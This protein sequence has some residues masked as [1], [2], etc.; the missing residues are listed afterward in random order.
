[1]NN[2]KFYIEMFLIVVLLIWCAFWGMS[3][4]TA[5]PST[6]TEFLANDSTDTHEY[7]PYYTCGHYS[8]DLARN[9]TENNITLGSVI[10]G[11][12]PTFRGHQN[13]I[14]NYYMNND[15]V[16]LIEPQ[17]DQVLYLNDTMYIYYRIYPDG[18][19]VP[20]NWK[21]NLAHTGKII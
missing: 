18:V 2:F 10:L 13:H 4:V 14:M 3:L 16:M 9:A 5:E 12:H 6:L 7:L 15:I 11:Y 1:M 20:S 19:Q 21:Y 17:T 8:R